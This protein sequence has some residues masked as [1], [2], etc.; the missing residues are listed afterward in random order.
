MKDLA[1]G[2]DFSVKLDQTNDLATVE[3]LEEF[4]QAIVV[5]LTEFMHSELPGI[6]KGGT[7]KQKI[8]LQVRRVAKSLNMLDQVARV[9]INEKLT[10]PDTFEVTI[11]YISEDIEPFSAEIN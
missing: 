7:T 5:H 8:R 3:G 6:R 10:E 9:E 1:L 2:T 11:E 4:E